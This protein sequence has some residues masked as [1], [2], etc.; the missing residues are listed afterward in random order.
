MPPFLLLALL[1]MFV[2]YR[3]GISRKVLFCTDLA[4]WEAH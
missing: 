4:A 3:L 2:P 1:R